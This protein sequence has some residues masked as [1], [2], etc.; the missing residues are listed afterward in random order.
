VNYW[1]QREKRRRPLRN[2]KAQA[3]FQAL[4]GLFRPISRMVRSKSNLDLRDLFLIGAGGVIAA[5]MADALLGWA[6]LQDRT[7]PPSQYRA[8]ESSRYFSS[9]AD[10]RK[11]RAAPLWRGQPGYR[12]GLDADGDGIACEF[13]LP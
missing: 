8:G 1:A 3:T 5:L 7:R 6:H 2:S 12:S 11:S 4:A 9:C 10:A 13:Y